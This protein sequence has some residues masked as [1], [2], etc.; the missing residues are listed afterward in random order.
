MSNASL[1]NTCDAPMCKW[2]LRM[3]ISE[4]MKVVEE[5]RVNLNKNG[6]VD[7]VYVVKKCPDYQ[8]YKTEEEE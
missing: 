2:L 8:K 6:G 7:T 3:E 5:D 1:Y 4:G